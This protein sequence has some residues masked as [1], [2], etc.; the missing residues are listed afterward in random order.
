MNPSERKALEPVTPRDEFVMVRR[1]VPPGGASAPSLEPVDV[2][3][4]LEEKKLESER[5][6]ATHQKWG[7]KSEASWRQEELLR[8]LGSNEVRLVAGR[9]SSMGKSLSLPPARDFS[10]RHYHVFR[11]ECA[12][13]ATTAVNG[14]DLAAVCGAVA[15][16]A[17]TLSPLVSCYR[18]RSIQAWPPAGGSCSLNWASMGNTFVGED[19]K[20]RDVP[21]GIT[22]TGGLKFVPSK[23]SLASNW[24][25]TNIQTGSPNVFVIQ[26]SVGTIVDV[27]LDFCYFAAGLNQFGLQTATGA[28]ATVNA[29]YFAGLDNW[30]TSVAAYVALHTSALA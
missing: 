8:K 3:D 11:F 20:A 23:N 15:E 21:T 5:L 27:E 30:R 25:N 7:G 18:I 17:T 6:L 2:L 24:I 22:V 13:A 29:L 14:V 16:T 10:M 28:S 19:I 26:S 12:N 9:A 1:V 4:R